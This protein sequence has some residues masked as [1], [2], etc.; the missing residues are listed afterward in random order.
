MDIKR[1]GAGLGWYI[2]KIGILQ[3]SDFSFLVLFLL[4][5]KRKEKENKKITTK[6]SDFSFLV[7][8]L[9]KYKR[10]EKEN[11]KITTKKSDFSFLVLFPYKCKS[12]ERL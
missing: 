6:K 3:K 11:K 5:Y 2:L 4:R 9:L 8:F 12:S 7:L 1:A 10:K